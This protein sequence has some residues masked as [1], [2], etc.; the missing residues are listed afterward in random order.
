[1]IFKAFERKPLPF[2]RPSALICES[3]VKRGDAVDAKE[4]NWPAD[5]TRKKEGEWM[6]EDGEKK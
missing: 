4:K 3:A 1:M 2:F 6:R 5:A